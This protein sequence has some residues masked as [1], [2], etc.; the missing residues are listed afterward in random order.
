[1]VRDSLNILGPSDTLIC[2]NEWVYPARWYSATG[3]IKPG[4]RWVDSLTGAALSDSI[5]VTQ[6]QAWLIIASDGCSPDYQ[7]TVHIQAADS[8]SLK[9]KEQIEGIRCWLDSLTTSLEVMGGR[10]TYLWNITRPGGDTF[11]SLGNSLPSTTWTQYGAYVIKIKDACNQQLLE[12][13]TISPSQ[14]ISSVI[15]SIDSACSRK[16][17]QLQLKSKVNA[18]PAWAEVLDQQGVVLAQKSLLDSLEVIDF[19]PTLSNTLTVTLQDACDFRDTVQVLVNYLEKPSLNL[20]NPMQ[21]CAQEILNQD[22]Q[23]QHLRWN[24]QL[25]WTLPAGVQ[26]QGSKLTGNPDNGAQISIK[27][28]D[29]CFGDTQMIIDVHRLSEMEMKPMDSI[30]CTGEKIDLYPLNWKDT[31]QQIGRAIRLK[32]LIDGQSQTIPKIVTDKRVHIDSLRLTYADTHRLGLEV[33]KRNGQA[34][35]IWTQTIRVVNTPVADFIIDLEPLVQGKKFSTINRS[36][37]ANRYK[38]TVDAVNKGNQTNIDH[39]LAD[40]GWAE[41]GLWAINEWG[42]KD[43]IK[44]LYWV[45]RPT[46]A[47][48]PTAFTPNGDGLNNVWYPQGDNIKSYQIRV[49]TRWGEKVFDGGENEPFTGY[50]QGELLMEGAYVAATTIKDIQNQ[51]H[52]ENQVILLLRKGE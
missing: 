45:E 23:W 8:L 41:I 27:I 29:Q 21:L 37:Y 3:G 28:G 35:A 1:S 14:K 33:Q 32:K 36:Q 42:C 16:P 38:W 2:H 5:Q 11:S 18:Y 9:N 51:I 44:Q 6:D 47:Y 17:L 48:Y 7:K 30:F 31:Q 49:Y 12:Q 25:E 43:S 24:T 19:G 52:Q 10:P 50:Y 13:I 26:N 15:A 40:T 4:L 20:D 22:Y 39:T 34:C 46:Q